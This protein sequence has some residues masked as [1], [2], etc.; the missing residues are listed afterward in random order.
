MTEFCRGAVGRGWSS[1]GYFLF[2]GGSS[3][4]MSQYPDGFRLDAF[5]TTV[6]FIV[7]S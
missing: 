4:Y 2:I 1:F 7:L 3:M 5:F 6:I